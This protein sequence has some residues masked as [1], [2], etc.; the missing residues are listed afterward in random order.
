LRPV[1][2]TFPT[3]ASLDLLKSWDVEYVLVGARAYG[4]E[5]PEIRERLD[6][7]DALQLVATFD[8]EPVYHSGWLTESLPDLQRSLVADQ[9]YVYR[10]E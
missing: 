2:W 4:Q 8:E 9:I 6:Q 7:F 1:L 10:L 5:W 3:T